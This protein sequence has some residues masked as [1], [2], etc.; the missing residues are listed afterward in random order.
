MDSYAYRELF[1]TMGFCTW[2]WANTYQHRQ[3]NS[4]K[5]E[6]RFT[7]LANASILCG[8][9][10]IFD[11]LSCRARNREDFSKL[12]RHEEGH[13]CLTRWVFETGQVGHYV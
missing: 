6:S 9:I 11:V 3:D 10:L 7:F 13:L 1:D 5:V 8:S 4:R 12:V 2:A